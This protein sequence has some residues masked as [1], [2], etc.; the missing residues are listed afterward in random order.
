MKPFDF[1]TYIKNNPLL[2]ELSPDT[3]KSAINVS[4]QRGTDRRTQKLG[5]LYFNKFIGMPLLGGKIVDIVVSNPQQA[6]YKQVTIQVEHEFENAPVVPDSL[7]HSFVHYDI[8]ADTFDVG[9][10]ERKDA[11]VLSKIAQKINPDTKYK[12]TGKYFD[13]KGHR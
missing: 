3:F 13:I 2:K 6:N 1:N 11:V 7:K 10:I 8:D 12:E 5:Q 4:K 9:E